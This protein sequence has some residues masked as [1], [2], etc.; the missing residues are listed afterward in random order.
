VE[1][2]QRWVHFR[3]RDV[4]YPDAQQMLAELHGDDL[5]QGKVVD[6]SDS[7]GPDGAFAVVEVDGIAQP[8]IV[9]VQRILGAL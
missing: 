5:L 1:L 4:Y 9:S 7:G 6:L 3:I 2:R 8:V